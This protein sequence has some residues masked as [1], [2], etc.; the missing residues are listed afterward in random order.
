MHAF[1]RIATRVAHP[2]DGLDFLKVNIGGQEAV[3]HRFIAQKI[4]AE[5]LFVIIRK[6]RYDDR[7]RTEL[8]LHQQGAEKNLR[9][10]RCRRRF[11][12]RR[13]VF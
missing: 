4:G 5:V 2:L 11:P 10:K 6:Q 8:F 7:I 3:F 13:P 9:P 1:I 12:A